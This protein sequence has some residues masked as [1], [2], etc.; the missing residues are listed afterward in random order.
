MTI[1]TATRDRTEEQPGLTLAA[2]VRKYTLPEPFADQIARIARE[3]AEIATGAPP[4][5]RLGGDRRQQLR[6]REMM[7]LR[8]SEEVRAMEGQM[9]ARRPR[10]SLRRWWRSCLKI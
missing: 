8:I 7:L 4:H 5:A 9:H 10:F 2:L 1:D 6:V 3:I